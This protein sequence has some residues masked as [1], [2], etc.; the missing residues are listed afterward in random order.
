MILNLLLTDPDNIP[1][2]VI[3]PDPNG[4]L[5]LLITVIATIITI[6]AG[7][8]INKQHK[9]ITKLENRNGKAGSIGIWI[10]TILV[11]IL[12]IVLYIIFYEN[13]QP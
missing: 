4:L 6:C 10:I 7:Y 13:Y 12:I 2:I 5:P 11:C 9:Q 1:D 3:Q 8:I